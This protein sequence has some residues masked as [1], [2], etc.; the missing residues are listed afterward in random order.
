MKTP[1]E[2]FVEIVVDGKA[3]DRD[4]DLYT[5]GVDKFWIPHSQLITKEPMGG[6]N[7]RIEIPEWLAI[8]KDM[9]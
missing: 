6:S 8:K 2:F 3:T 1:V 5:D 7:Y 4:A 9:V